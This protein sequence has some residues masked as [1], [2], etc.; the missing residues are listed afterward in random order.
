M[1]NNEFV[2]GNLLPTNVYERSIAKTYDLYLHD[3]I[4]GPDDYIEWNQLFRRASANDVIYVHINS[5]GGQINTAIQM[6]RAMR[7]TEATIV[8][9][10]E[11]ACM[12]AATM[13]FL[14]GDVCEVSD[15]SQFM[16]HTYSGGSW[17]KGS[18]ILAQ[19]MHDT[20]WIT[21]LMFDVYSGFLTD[22]EINGIIEGKDMWCSPD[23][24]IDRL[25]KRAL[26]LEK[27]KKQAEKQEAAPKSTRKRAPKAK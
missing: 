10:I 15:H 5:Y 22:D 18:E 19:I 12:S 14:Q 24:V 6:I 2:L 25:N 16:V 27:Q 8:T 23:E 1:N 13:I 21:T 7:E 17:G 9:S 26:Y 20:D 3:V 4:D 11:G